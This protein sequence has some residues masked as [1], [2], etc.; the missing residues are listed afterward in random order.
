MENKENIDDSSG[1]SVT[2]I[3]ASQF[4]DVTVTK[5]E[6]A[7][8]TSAS[9]C[10]STTEEPLP[11]CSKSLDQIPSVS[12]EKSSIELSSLHN[13]NGCD[14]QHHQ[15]H[16][17]ADYMGLALKQWSMYLGNVL[18]NFIHKECKN[19]NEQCSSTELHQQQ[20]SHLA[21][22]VGSRAT[23]FL[24]AVA[25]SNSNAGT[26]SLRSNNGG[27]KVNDAEQAASDAA[28]G[29]GAETV[30]GDT[31]TIVSQGYCPCCHYHSHLQQQQQQQQQQNVINQQQQQ[32][33]LAAAVVASQQQQQQ[34]QS[35]SSNFNPGYYNYGFPPFFANQRNY[36]S[37]LKEHF[38]V[39]SYLTGDDILNI[40]CHN[41]MTR[42]FGLQVL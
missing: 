10:D 32:V 9:Q 2:R 12:C 42:T 26:N 31:T 35:C 1:V 6:C 11:S 4:D 39:S 16:Q 21:A 28:T 15:Q 23:N 34:Q 38:F 33:M 20:L 5:I 18:L 29:E 3:E 24:Q 25:A 14:Q 30:I 19:N 37:L 13:G 36:V 40:F 27:K 7:N 8:V 17:Q 22:A 41:I